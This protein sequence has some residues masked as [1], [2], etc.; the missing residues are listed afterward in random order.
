MVTSLEPTLKPVS[1]LTEPSLG[2]LK[3]VM[4]AYCHFKVLMH[5]GFDLFC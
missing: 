1:F 4:L 3:Y 2:K 5:N